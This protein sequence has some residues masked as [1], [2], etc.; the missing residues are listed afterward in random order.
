MRPPK[1]SDEFFYLLAPSKSITDFVEDV[2]ANVEATLSYKLE[3]HYSKAHVSLMKDSQPHAESF[4][5]DVDSKMRS[6][7]PFTVSVKNLNVLVQENEKRTIYLDIVYKT[8]IW[9]IMETLT[10]REIDFNPKITVVENL[11]IDD[12]IRVWRNLKKISFSGE[13]RCNHLTVL[14]KHT[15]RWVHHIDI[16]S[17]YV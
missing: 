15:Q 3:N 11:E 2:K 4:L 8:P 14:R 10:G 5:Y 9:E 12:F 16:P 1:K 6:V 17:A 7:R 13:F